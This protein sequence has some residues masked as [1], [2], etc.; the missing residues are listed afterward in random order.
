MPELHDTR[1][2]ALLLDVLAMLCGTVLGAIFYGGLWWTVR[3]LAT[4]RRPAL[5][6]FVSMLLRM[7]VALGGL[8]LVGRG[9]WVRLL[10]CLLGFLLARVAVTWLAR[11]WAAESV[12]PLTGL[13][14]AP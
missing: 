7:G 4:S 13:R 5:A 9:D 8:Y 11:R 14:H 2:V 6:V 1:M 3:Q 12:V 10:S